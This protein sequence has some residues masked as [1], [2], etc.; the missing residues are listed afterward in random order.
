MWQK[1]IIS[2]IERKFKLCLFCVIEKKRK[3]CVSF[4][5]K[6]VFFTKLEITNYKV[7]WKW[8]EKKNEEEK[9]A[10]M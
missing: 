9:L 4:S 10:K 2:K 8:K 1:K 7:K 3:F 5:K 6:N